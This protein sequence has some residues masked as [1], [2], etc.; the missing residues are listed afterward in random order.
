MLHRSKLALLFMA[1]IH[2][3]AAGDVRDAV[4]AAVSAGVAVAVYGQLQEEAPPEFQV[5]EGIMHVSPPEDLADQMGPLDDETEMSPDHP[6]CDNPNGCH[7][8]KFQGFNV[9]HI[10]RE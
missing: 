6:E 1:L 4:S 3:A 10:H 7:H 2:A 9:V 5:D 8:I